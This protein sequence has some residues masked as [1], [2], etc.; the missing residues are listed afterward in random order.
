MYAQYQSRAT[1]LF[2]ARI[3]SLFS[4]FFRFA[5]VRA[6]QES[7]H[8]RAALASWRYIGEVARLARSNNGAAERPFEAIPSS[9]L[10]RYRL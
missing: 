1:G 2:E 9:A 8:C 3:V 5:L 4:F 7:N 10:Q 6:A